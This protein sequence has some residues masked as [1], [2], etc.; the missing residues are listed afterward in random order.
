MKPDLSKLRDR[1]TIKWTSLF[2]P[3][4]VKS[5][6]NYFANDGYTEQPI[7][8]E[9]DIAEMEQR[10]HFSMEAGESLEFGYW[11]DGFVSSVR[12][13]VRYIDVITK[14]LRIVEEGDSG[15]VLRL[16][17]SELVSVK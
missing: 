12:G 1:G 3:E 5:L 8:D 14:E 9:Y 6:R 16:R 15:A 13:R 7:L 4:H 11:R 10:I 2:L 17:F